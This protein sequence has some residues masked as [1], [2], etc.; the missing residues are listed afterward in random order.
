MGGEGWESFEHLEGVALSN[1]CASKA[2]P[3]SCCCCWWWCRRNGWYP[4]VLG[5][6]NVAAKGRIPY[7]LLAIMDTLRLFPGQVGG[8]SV[9]KAV[10]LLHT[11]SRSTLPHPPRAAC[12]NC[13]ATLLSRPTPSHPPRC[14]PTTQPCPQVPDVDAVLHTADFPCIKR[15]WAHGSATP[16]PMLGYQASVRHFDIPFPDYTHWG[17]EHMYIQVG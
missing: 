9:S 15:S 5:P 12:C 17:H 16:L 4:A 1:S 2:M 13:A 8:C 6:G 3:C 14:L 7:A 10:A 11:V